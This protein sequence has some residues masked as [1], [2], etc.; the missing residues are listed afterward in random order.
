MKCALLNI[1]RS[2]IRYIYP[3]EN[4]AND[5]Q[6][7][8]TFSENEQPLSAMKIFVL[9]F[10]I[11][12]LGIGT[13]FGL[14]QFSVKSGT[15]LIPSALNP[16]APA[17]GKIVGSSDTKTFKD[18][19]E[20]TLK[21]GGIDGEGQYHLERPGGESQNVYLTSSL[22]DLS[23]FIGK[24]IKVW[25]ETQKAQKAGWLMDVGRVEVK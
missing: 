2:L 8:H 15:S 7:M 1:S 20:G 21:D 22:V 4:N 3:M 10:V 23:E 13:G 24:K 6:I 19:A 17:K 12:L 9:F 14:A 5:S 16:N 18:T 11:V 25:G